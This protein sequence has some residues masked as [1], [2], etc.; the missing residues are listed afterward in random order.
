MFSYIDKES[1][2][3]EYVSVPEQGGGKLFRKGWENQV[4]F[5]LLVLVTQE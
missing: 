2:Q 5:T 1:M 4:M 3:E